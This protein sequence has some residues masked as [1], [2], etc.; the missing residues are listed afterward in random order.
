MSNLLDDIGDRTTPSLTSQTFEIF[1]QVVVAIRSHNQRPR[2][3][4]AIPQ[5]AIDR[6]RYV[7]RV[8]NHRPAGG[9]HLDDLLKR[10]GDFGYKDL[11]TWSAPRVGVD[12]VLFRRRERSVLR[13]AT[14]AAVSEELT[15]RG[16]PIR[17]P[18][19]VGF[20]QLSMYCQT[21]NH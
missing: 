16:M 20:S 6:R 11:S 13:S 21:E 2:A 5:T 4:H 10:I 14:N 9:H 7:S 12:P 3:P 15:F 1:A 17:R 8:L 18:A 19:K